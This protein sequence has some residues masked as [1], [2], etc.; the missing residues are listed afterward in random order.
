MA[1][2]KK[3]LLITLQ[4][5]YDPQVL[6][7]FCS[8]L[9][10]FPVQILEAHQ[11]E[12]V[13][14]L[15]AMLSLHVLDSDSQAQLIA[16]LHDLA[17]K[18][19]LQILLTETSPS[20]PPV[21]K[22]SYVLTLLSN[23]LS[24]KSLE[25]LLNYLQEKQ[26]QL[27]G[28]KT[29]DSRKIHVLELKIRSEKVLKRQEFI[30][31]LIGL[32]EQH[33]VD[34]ALQPD[35]LFRRNKRLIFFDADMTFVQC[36]V[37]N[38]LSKLS[39]NEKAVEAIT[40]RAMHGELNFE[41]SLKERVA[42]LKGISINDVERV[43]LNM[44]Y[45]PGVGN[46]VKTLKLLGYKVGIVSGGFSVVIDHIKEHFGLDYGFG[47]TLEVK[48][49]LL[50]GRV[51][52]KVIDGSQ[53]AVLLTQVAEKEQISLEQVIAVG[54]GANDL[55]MLSCAGLGIAFNA[56]RFLQERT[57][58]NLSQANLDAILYFLGISREEIDSLK[59]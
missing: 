38:E 33:H 51:L 49:G 57:S 39:G 36:E 52:G 46:L 12:S 1:S 48:D 42:M 58:G 19:G 23:A 3:T 45:T 53:K 26:L 40:H 37:V 15:L 24:S 34:F 30:S 35:N 55:N 7:D 54:D 41:E 9:S 31:D 13:Q 32:Q 6:Q 17:S 14:Q 29:L 43:I 59:V 47:N 11:M 4:G 25:E 5:K 8:T 16:A 44:P 56:K 2:I 50:T 18:K 10:H 22:N 28:I 20:D 21:P 27:V